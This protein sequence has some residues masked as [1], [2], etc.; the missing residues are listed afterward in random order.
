[1]DTSGRDRS[2]VRTT[3]HP[4]LLHRWPSALGLAAAVLSL[5]SG[6]NRESGAITVVVASLC[7]LG[8][9]AFN[10]P[11]VG[12]AGI[13]GGSIV[14]VASELAGLPWWA[15]AGITSLVLIVAG[16]AVRAPRVPLAAQ[17]LALAVYG[18]LAV[19][20]LFLSPRVGLAMAGAVLACHA[21]WDVVL[22]R[23]NQTVPRSL[24]EFCMVLD[25]LAGGGIVVVAVTG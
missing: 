18:G 1:M 7:Y 24:T 17:A 11:W 13:L 4:K 10:R 3:D 9:A 25:V 8:A 2:R 19:V 6:V 5:A 23:R 15:G 21:I 16:V 20:T 12:W 22:Y 14:I